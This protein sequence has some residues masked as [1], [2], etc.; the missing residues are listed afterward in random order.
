[1]SLFTEKAIKDS[2]LSKT[3][4]TSEKLLLSSKQI[5]SHQIQDQGDQTLS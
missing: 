1:M 3:Y 4:Y 2:I 5:E